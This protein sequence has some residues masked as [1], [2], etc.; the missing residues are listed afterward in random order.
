SDLVGEAREQ[1]LNDARAAGLPDDD[2]PLR[3]GGTG[4]RAYAEA[5]SVYLAFCYSSIRQFW[6]NISAWL[7]TVEN[8]QPVFGRQ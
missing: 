1:A 2:I 8:M 5:V 3:D 7:S 6:S 4:A